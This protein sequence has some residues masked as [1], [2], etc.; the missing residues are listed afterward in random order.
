[1]I[2]YVQ[3][4]REGNICTVKGKI[5]PEHKVRGKSYSQTITL[6]E[7]AEKV[8]SCVCHDCAASS[9]IFT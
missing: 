4:K 6:D 2:G 9:G 7:Q 8:I 5:C 3:I 1:M